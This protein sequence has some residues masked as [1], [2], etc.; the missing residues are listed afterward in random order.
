MG[1]PPGSVSVLGVV[2]GQDNVIAVTGDGFGYQTPTVWSSTDGGSTW[3]QLGQGANSQ[4][5]QIS[6]VGIRFDASDPNTF[7]VY[8]FFAQGNGGLYRTTDGGNTFTGI[9]IPGTANDEIEDVYS[10]DGVVLATQ[11]EHEQSVYKSTDGGNTWTNIGANLPAG[12]A[13]SEY[14]YIINSSTYLVGCSFAIDG[15]WDTGGGTTGIYLTTDGGTTWTQV[16]AGYE[17]FGSPAS[18]NGTL[19]W[20]YLGSTGGG[21]V[22]SSD[23]GVT[24]SVLP[25]D[26]LIYS[27]TPTELQGGQIAS[28]NT[29]NQVVLYAQ[30]SSSATTLTGTIGLSAPFGLAYDS[31]RN[32]LFTWEM[33]GGIERLDL[34]N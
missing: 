21:I 22:A 26:Q 19:Y 20:N 15:T 8:G 34:S 12:T 16:G 25:T 5:L 17:V 23:N 30:G 29:A 32:A 3:V 1:F 28:V 14:V 11:H 9:Q 10:A 13:N 24:W 4:A 33:D 7:W 6:P 31:V 18:I 2:P 27:V